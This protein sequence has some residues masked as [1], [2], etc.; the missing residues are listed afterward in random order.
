MISSRENLRGFFTSPSTDTAPGRGLKFP[1]V[2][3]GIGFVHAEFVEIVV[4]GD[5]VV[6]V[7]LFRGAEGAFDQAAEFRAREGLYARR[8]Q[9][10]E[11]R[12][13]QCGG[14]GEAHAAEEFA[15]IEI[16]RFRRDIGVGQF[17]G[18]A[19]QHDGAIPPSW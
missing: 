8:S 1:G 12:A 5:V 13:G 10:P 3:G 14:S 17:G 11:A 6:G 7:L 9:I 15:A 2:F 18:L 16:E 19:D 4:V